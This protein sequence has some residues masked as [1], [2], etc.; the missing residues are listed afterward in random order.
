MKSQCLTQSH[1]S[2]LNILVSTKDCDKDVVIDLASPKSDNNLYSADII[3]RQ[4]VWE[5]KYGLWDHQNLPNPPQ[6]PLNDIVREFEQIEGQCYLINV[7]LSPVPFES[8]PLQNQVTEDSLLLMNIYVY[9]KGFTETSDD[10]SAKLPILSKNNSEEWKKLAQIFHDMQ[11]V[12]SYQSASEFLK[13]VERH[14]QKFSRE[15]E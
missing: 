14:A 7:L 15:T 8:E 13:N 4:V 10:D 12:T 5:I 2:E 3:G 6:T 11:S 9:S 1:L